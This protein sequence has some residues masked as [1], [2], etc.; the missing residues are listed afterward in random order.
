VKRRTRLNA[1]MV[2]GTGAW[3]LLISCFLLPPEAVNAA[4]DKPAGIALPVGV[5]YS[6]EK[7]RDPFEPYVKKKEPMLSTQQL[8]KQEDFKPPSMTIQGISWGGRYPQAIVNNKVVRVGDTVS[9]AV[10]VEIRRDGIVFSFK[11]RQFGVMAP[12]L[13]PASQKTKTSKY[14]TRK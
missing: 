2:I 14:R 6:A 10:V 12:A 11:N 5:K 1:A 7:L 13:D 3:V 9:D 4:E 8:T